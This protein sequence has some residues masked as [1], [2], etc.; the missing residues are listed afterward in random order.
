MICSQRCR[1]PGFTLTEA[2]V[3]VL[4]FTFFMGTLFAII[5]HGFRSYSI[6]VARADVTTEARRLVLFLEHELRSTEYFSIALESRTIQGV[7]RDGFSFVSMRDWAGPNSFD[8]I[9]ARPNWDRY[10]IYYA[11][12]ELPTGQLVRMVIDPSSSSDVGSYPY[13]PF[14]SSPDTFMPDDPLEVPKTDLTSSR[15]LAGKVKNF[16][17]KLLPVTQEIDI[18]I[19]LRQNGIMT[20][21]A[22][23]TR[24]GGTFELHYRVKPQNTK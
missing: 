12:Q 2:L 22:D 19:L 4:V 5:S 6:A 24:E 17:V 3:T 21:R 18:T 8:A 20:R 7:H 1:A 16:E 10:F 15:V 23:R 14:A 13:S 9:E 11:T